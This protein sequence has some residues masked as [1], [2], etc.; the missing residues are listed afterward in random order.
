MRDSMGGGGA[1]AVSMHDLFTY[2][3]EKACVNQCD[4]RKFLSTV[5][6][7]QIIVLRRRLMRLLQ[8]MQHVSD[9]LH[10]RLD[11]QHFQHLYFTR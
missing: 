1:V 5:F 3:V 4:I 10:V 6:V 9:Y 11:Q 7:M 8:T 2:T